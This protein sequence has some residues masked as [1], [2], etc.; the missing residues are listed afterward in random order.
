MVLF[1]R[2]ILFSIIC[3]SV[4]LVCEAS[5]KLD[6]IVDLKF[7]Y[8]E[9]VTDLRK[10]EY[11][12]L[13]GFLNDAISDVQRI[14]V[15]N[16]LCWKQFTSDPA[17][18]LIYAHEQLK[19]A[20][21]IG[22]Q[23]G[24]SFGYDNLTFLYQ[25]FGD[26]KASIEYALKSLVV[27]EDMQDSTG[28]AIC[29]SAIGN[30]YYS[31]D[32]YDKALEFYLRTL[33]IE[34]DLKNQGSIIK[35]HTNI[36]SLHASEKKH[37][38]ARD[39]LIKAVEMANETNKDRERALFYP[40][41]ELGRIEQVESNLNDA[42]VYYLLA[43][44]QAEKLNGQP[45]FCVVYTRLGS[46]Y[47]ELKKPAKSEK[48][49]GKALTIA[50]TLGDKE[51]V[52]K[53]YEELS[54]SFYN[55]NS[56]RKAYEH[57][58]LFGEMKDSLISFENS[59]II[60]D[61]EIKYESDK[62]E[63]LLQIQDLELDRNEADIKQSRTIQIA[64][65][66]G[67]LLFLLL[68][69]VLYRGIQRKKA[70]NKVIRAQKD[71]VE[72][73][74]ELIAEQHKEV[75]VLYKLEE[76]AK[77]EIQELHREVTDSIEYASHIQKAILTS[78]A[79]WERMLQSHFILFKPRDIVSGDFYW[80]FETPSNKKMWIAADCTGHGVPG[81]FMS[82]LGNTFLNEIVIE[83]GIHDADAILN[84]LRDHIIKAL[85]S[86]SATV[87]EMEMK[88]GMDLALCIL[89]DD[90]TLEYAGA[91]NPLWIIS[92]RQEVFEGAKIT[93]N[94]EKTVFI[95][96][97]RADKQPI[98]KYM[99]MEPFTA[100]KIQLEEGDQVYTFSDGYADQFGGLKL[101]KYMAK[102]LKKFLFSIADQPMYNQRKLLLQ[103]FNDW[104]KETDQVDDVCI[105]GVKV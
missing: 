32:N 105:I 83:Q 99:L 55:N 5:Y 80:A 8:I 19:L 2:F 50:K 59:R 27:K 28:I 7:P 72:K 14:Y 25:H 51:S 40:Y 41:I 78:D 77:I 86:D 63:Q 69:F 76:K 10:I 102:R 34:Q 96:E 13:K 90:N 87:S 75:A 26:N 104:R 44:E 101:K 95:H 31:L 89:H 6:S 94:E 35:M 53:A 58:V 61:M 18:A 85:S 16:A 12:E 97:I 20:K 37:E 17:D 22:F 84:S 15:Y 52:K 33:K 56:F 24:L 62:K 68:S 70:A 45:E 66:G 88:D 30:I 21:K 46:V 74:K 100:S 57:R 4:E 9:G 43:L 73:Q 11:N 48:Y 60:S 92:K 98:G 71:E 3:F 38:L 39:Y 81:G 42:L 91:N 67:L 103:E 1:K 93:A 36:G 29:L 49:L 47:N 65:S 64:L 54:L 82:M 23:D 79:Y